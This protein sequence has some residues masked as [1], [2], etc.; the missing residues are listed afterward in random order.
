MQ[1]SLIHLGLS[2]QESTVYQVALGLGTF[3]ASTLGNILKIPRST[4]RYTCEAL[5]RK[6]LMI[7]TKKAN[8]KL[9][10][11]ENPTK[12][13][14]LLYDEEEELKKKKEHLAFTIKELQEKYDPNTKLPKVTFYEGLDWIERM[15]HGLLTKGSS[16]YSFSAGDYFLQ[17]EP[18]LIQ[19][20]RTKSNYAH[21]NVQIIRAK[22]YEPLH[23][24]DPS[25]MQTQY[26]Q[27]IN[28]LRIDIQ[29]AGDTLSIASM[30]NDYPI[31]ILIKHD[32]IAQGF[33]QIF[34]EIWS[35]EKHYD[36]N[37]SDV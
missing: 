32:A 16:L 36:P 18:E 10:V 8:T 24:N 20:Y 31:G 3:A 6:W 1:T 9:F 30:E 7:E 28:E 17:K 37:A 14:S 19:R 12:L 21:K 4:A 26:Y 15:F 27:N 34:Q 33:Q 5:V 29:I 11:A 2:S 35:L 25:F 13:Y 23:K 22:K